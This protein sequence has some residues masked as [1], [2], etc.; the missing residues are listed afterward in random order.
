MTPYSNDSNTYNCQLQILLNA[1]MNS[2]DDD[3]KSDAAADGNV[4]SDTATTHD[5]ATKT[6]N[7]KPHGAGATT[8]GNNKTKTTNK[9]TAKNK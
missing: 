1:A 6:A 4:G 2:D 5:N 3:A 9:Q 8:R 7:K